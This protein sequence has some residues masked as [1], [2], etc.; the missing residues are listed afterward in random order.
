MD[1][2]TQEMLAHARVADG[3]TYVQVHP[4]FLYESVWNLILLIVIIIYRKHK[5]F[6]GEIFLMYLWGYGM[7]RVW[8]EGLRSDSL[9]LPFFNM[10]VSQM[11]AAI[12]V[13]AC[14]VL[15]VKKR[16]DTVKKQAPAGKKEQ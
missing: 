3:V 7:G 13:L 12:C 8:I 4:T 5:K 6:D 16:M 14:S 11:I 9:M 10:K 2:I 15:I 1:D